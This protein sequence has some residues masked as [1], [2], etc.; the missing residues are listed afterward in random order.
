MNDKHRTNS[1]LKGSH[2]MNVA[3]S[4]VHPIGNVYLQRTESEIE[5]N[6]L[7]Q[8]VKNSPEENMSQLEYE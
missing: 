2:F 6:P 3:Y 4:P 7:I 1:S 5:E 8:T